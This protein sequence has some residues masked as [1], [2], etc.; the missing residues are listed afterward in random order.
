MKKNELTYIIQQLV[1]EEIKKQLPRALTE[2]LE[3]FKGKKAIVTEKK[4]TPK[5]ASSVEE[6]FR[7]SL[8]EMFDGNGVINE[9][10]A[11]SHVAASKKFTN[12]PVLNNILNETRPFS[13]Q[14]RTGAAGGL[15]AM[16]EAQREAAVQQ[17]S[18]SY[19]SGM[20]DMGSLMSDS[21][22]PNITPAV[23]D[24]KIPM[25]DLGENVSVM[26]VKQHV[27]LVVQ[28]ALTKNYSKMM[29]LIDKKQ[30]RI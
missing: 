16:M 26:D 24:S 10:V 3:N 30:G 28:Q 6:D 23:A 15:A 1:A 13:S 12:D 19:T 20:P 4:A 9:Q 17:S 11:S 29:K 14:Q 7:L 18:P 25:A 5:P 21:P 22:E 2:I 27:P 8:R